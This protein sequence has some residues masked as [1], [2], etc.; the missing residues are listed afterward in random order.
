MV[1]ADFAARVAGGSSLDASFVLM[2]V[3]AYA[4]LALFAIA[5]F[6]LR[7]DEPRTETPP[8]RTVEQA[9]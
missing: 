1:V 2:R 9:R 6:V 8:L 4:Q 5:A 7:A 3:T